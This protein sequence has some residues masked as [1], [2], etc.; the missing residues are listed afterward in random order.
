VGFVR[1]E[2]WIEERPSAVSVALFRFLD[3]R[4]FRNSVALCISLLL[5]AGLIVALISLGRTEPPLAS[6][7]QQSIATFD[8]A[9]VSAQ[10]PGASA[11]AQALQ[12]VTASSQTE[13]NHAPTAPREWSVTAMPIAPP[14]PAS[15]PTEVATSA[16]PV[17]GMSVT[18]S[19]S[20]AGYDPYAFASYR[21]PDPSRMGASSLQPLPDAVARLIAALGAT[22][23][24]RQVA[25]RATVDPMGHVVQAELMSDAAPDV[26]A[27]LARIAPGFPLCAA[28]PRRPAATSLVVTLTV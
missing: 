1:T 18:G 12:P 15:D 27:R 4:W 3:H 5:D 14:A 9:S 23:G 11:A 13:A 2:S 7:N 17:Q 28:D 26:A 8:I 21:R 24:A 19:G 25:M 16:A 22:G 10:S 20:G 6:S